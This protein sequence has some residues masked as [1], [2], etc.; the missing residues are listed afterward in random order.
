MLNDFFFN[1]TNNGTWHVLYIYKKSTCHTHLLLEISE[2]ILNN[3]IVIKN[4]QIVF[5][6]N[7]IRKVSF[8][9]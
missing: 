9:Q 7:I 6:Y 5:S 2:K 4:G 8:R 1:E 3:K